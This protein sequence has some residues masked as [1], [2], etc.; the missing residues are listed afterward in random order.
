MKYECSL[1]EYKCKIPLFNCFV[2]DGETSRAESVVALGITLIPLCVLGIIFGIWGILNPIFGLEKYVYL[3]YIAIFF[4]AII[5]FFLIYLFRKIVPKYCKIIDYMITIE[6]LPNGI[7]YSDS[8]SNNSVFIPKEKI[9]SMGYCGDSFYGVD[10][11]YVELSTRVESSL[12]YATT[13]YNYE[14]GSLKDFFIPKSVETHYH[15]IIPD[16]S[17]DGIKIPLELKKMF[18]IGISMGMH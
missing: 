5:S 1:K 15:Y 8:R 10:N 18:G 13:C 17:D 3:F 14:G 9:L 16:I 12:S 4:C 6:I 11:E 2:A 7:N